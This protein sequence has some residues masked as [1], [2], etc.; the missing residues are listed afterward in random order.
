[1]GFCEVLNELKNRI[2]TK[3]DL[4]LDK[5][6][7]R[8]E[9]IIQTLANSEIEL[10][11]LQENID[12]ELIK[13]LQQRYRSKTSDLSVQQFFDTAIHTI[14]V[15]KNGKNLASSLNE[16]NHDRISS[17]TDQLKML[18]ANW[19]AITYSNTLDGVT[20]LNDIEELKK[21]GFGDI[22]LTILSTE[23]CFTIRYYNRFIEPFR[24]ADKI[25]RRLLRQIKKAVRPHIRPGYRRIEWTCVSLNIYSSFMY[26][27]AKFLR[28]VVMNCLEIWATVIQKL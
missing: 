8:C 9:K 13:C 28:N 20:D 14:L 15:D 26:H 17:Q 2:E 16:K 10:R 19:D 4:Y 25:W 12:S 1:M 23:A 18:L 3:G 21:E 27:C 7:V 11:K 22:D 5:P 24:K 6:R